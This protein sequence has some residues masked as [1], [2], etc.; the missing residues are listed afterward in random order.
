MNRAR[1]ESLGGRGNAS[2][3]DS[4][5]TGFLSPFPFGCDRREEGERWRMVGSSSDKKKDQRGSISKSWR[6]APAGMGSIFT[7]CPLLSSLTAA[8]R[9]PRGNEE[10]R[11]LLVAAAAA[12]A[13][14]VRQSASA[15]KRS[16]RRHFACRIDRKV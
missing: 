4:F 15:P 9:K 12:A 6:Y 2:A 7:T 5:Q 1:E 10:R 11:F 14:V 13:V 8:R 3:E 16:R